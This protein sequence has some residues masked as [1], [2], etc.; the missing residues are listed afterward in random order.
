MYLVTLKTALVEALQAVFDA[1]FPEED[2]RS[3]PV[4]IEFPFNSVDYPGIWVN[5]DDTQ[6]LTVAGIDHQETILNDV[7][8][9]I[10]ITRWKFGGTVTFT[11]SAMSSLERDRLYD[12]MVNVLAFGH[13]R[14]VTHEFR[15]KIENND[16]IAMNLDFDTLRP[17]GA[18]E[19]PET[20]WGTREM[21]YEKSLALDV[22]GEFFGDPVTQQLIPI[23]EIR[24]HGY[25]ED[26]EPV[27]DP[28]PEPGYTPSEWH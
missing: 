7:N 6:D 15:Q 8:E 24:V 22:I 11:M 27:P 17:T 10:P 13:Y 16:L 21:I 1:E 25:V 5:Y 9:S 14:S 4:S 28:A 23:G 20:P 3:L 2:F 26:V 18:N 12:Q 19:A